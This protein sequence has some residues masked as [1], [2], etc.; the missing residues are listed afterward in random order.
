MFRRIVEFIE[1]KFFVVMGLLFLFSICGTKLF[2]YFWDNYRSEINA[3]LL[4]FALFFERHF[5]FA[6]VFMAVFL[7]LGLSLI[8]YVDY[9]RS[10]EDG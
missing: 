5:E 7:T 9:K 2:F 3:T 4:Q 10:R 8:T 1:D 6:M